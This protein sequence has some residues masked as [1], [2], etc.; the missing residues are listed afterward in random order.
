MIH[1][2]H[3]IALCCS[4][5]HDPEN[6]RF[7]TELNRML[8]QH[9]CSLWIYNINTDLYWNEDILSP[10]TAVF[11]LLDFGHTDVVIVMDEK[12]KSH[13][14]TNH[15]IAESKRHG[16]PLVLIDGSHEG[17]SEVRYDYARGFELIV[18]HVLDVHHAKKLHFMGGMPGNPFSDER[19]KVFRDI[20]AEHGIPVT[21]EMISYGYFWAKPAKAIAEGMLTHGEVPEAVI[22]ANDIMAMNV[23]DVFQ[24]HGLRV[25]QDVIVTGF[26]GIDEIYFSRPTITSALCGAAGMSEC[27]GK[28]VLDALRHPE[29][30][31]KYLVEPEMLLHGSCGCRDAAYVAPLGHSHSFNDRFYRYQ[32]DIRSLTAICER[33]QTF[34]SIEESSYTLFGDTLQDVCCLINKRC[35]DDSLDYFQTAAAEPF[36]ETMLLFFDSDQMP[37]RQ[38]DMPRTD[39]IP[40]L[41][42]VMDRGYPLI[43][44][45]LG[46]MG[47]PIGYLCFHFQEYEIINYCRIPQISTT[48]SI[49]LGG[50]ISR[51]YQSYLVRRIEE[52]Y[53]FDPLTGLCNRLSFSKDFELLCRT[54]GKERI[55]L[56]VILSDLDGLKIIN[57]NCGHAAGDHAI[58]TMAKTLRAECPHDALCVRF[59]G[60]EMVA[61]IPGD[62]DPK[63]LCTAIENS[64]TRFNTSSGLDYKVSA[65]VGYCRTVLTPDIDIEAI[66]RQADER[67]YAIKLE[68]K[69]RIRRGTQNVTSQ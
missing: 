14:V 34:N 48:L 7:A 51:R 5:L 2:K 11:D 44:C 64:L 6:A 33:M 57:D 22:C 66:I 12:I 62:C 54:R 17:C 46:F 32:D 31:G 63:A 39:I 13:T 9:N 37:F 24:A 16:I 35:T 38:Y 42:D 19:E 40:H 36:D 45:A 25:P 68:K 18:R 65:S 27:V 52:M 53:R 50:F 61:V 43:F 4:R 28:A 30:C 8:C 41:K 21:E 49:G 47:I 26:D 20:L 67:M 55:P 60:D 15:L 3:V 1:G 69:E 29:H 59:G 10:E 56:T 23:C 58:A